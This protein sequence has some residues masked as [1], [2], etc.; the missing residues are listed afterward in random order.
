VKCRPPR[1]INWRSHK[2]TQEDQAQTLTSKLDKATEEGEKDL[3]SR[4]KETHS[5]S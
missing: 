1:D 4:Q 5:H 3:K 2:K